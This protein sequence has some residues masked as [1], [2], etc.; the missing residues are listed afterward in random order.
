[1]KMKNRLLAVLAFGLLS[2]SAFAQE[3]LEKKQFT[4]VVASETNQRIGFIGSRSRGSL[5]I[6]SLSRGSLLIFR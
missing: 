2:S 5:F 3:G 6:G 4:R 1:M